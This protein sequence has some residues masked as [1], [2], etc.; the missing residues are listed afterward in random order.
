MNTYT[1]DAWVLVNIKSKEFGEVQKIFAGW[2]G[3]YCGSDSWKLSS[4]NLEML[5]DGEFLVFPQ[6]SSSTY[7]CHKDCQRM[8]GY[9]S[10]IW[11]GWQDQL[12][13]HPGYT[14]EINKVIY[15]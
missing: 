12:L 2:Y 7:R 8:T 9:M 10:N 6:Y 3:G 5:E 4:G 11:A 14:M 1:P 13:E 15:A